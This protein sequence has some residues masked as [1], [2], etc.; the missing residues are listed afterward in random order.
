MAAYVVTKEENNTAYVSTFKF[1]NYQ[2]SE[3]NSFEQL[4]CSHLT[5]SSLSLACKIYACSLPA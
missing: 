1:F 2:L 5:T 3:L 4:D